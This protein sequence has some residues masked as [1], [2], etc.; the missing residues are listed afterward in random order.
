MLMLLLCCSDF[1]VVAVF[2]WR[3]SWPDSV[4]LSLSLYLF[5]LGFFFC[6]CKNCCKTGCREGG[7]RERDGVKGSG[8]VESCTGRGGRASETARRSG[9]AWNGIDDVNV[10]SDA[11]SATFSFAGNGKNQRKIQLRRFKVL[12]LEAA[13]VEIRIWQFNNKETE[14]N[15]QLN[16]STH[17]KKKHT[18]KMII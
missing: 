14:K 9:D 18:H 7:F 6:C 15:I 17:L 1:V 13:A 3:Y 2:W 8:G 10:D 4:S 5:L 11:G 16:K 12:A